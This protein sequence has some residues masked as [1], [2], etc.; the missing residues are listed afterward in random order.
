MKFNLIFREKDPAGDGSEPP[1]EVYVA[2]NEGKPKEIYE[3][4]HKRYDAHDWESFDELVEDTLN[5]L[6]IKFSY[7]SDNALIF[8]A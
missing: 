1:N 2:V 6:G 8:D 3:E 7:I 5:A 4:F